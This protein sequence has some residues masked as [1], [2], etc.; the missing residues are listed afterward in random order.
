MRWVVFVLLSTLSSCQMEREAEVKSDGATVPETTFLN[1]KYKLSG[2]EIN[3]QGEKVGDEIVYERAVQ[4]EL[5]G[6]LPTF[7]RVKD[8]TPGKENEPIDEMYLHHSF[9]TSEGEVVFSGGSI[10]VRSRLY[11]VVQKDESLELGCTEPPAHPLTTIRLAGTRGEELSSAEWEELLAG[12][13]EE[14]NPKPTNRAEL[15]K[16]FESACGQLLM[17]SGKASLHKMHM[18]EIGGET[19]FSGIYH[20]FDAGGSHNYR[21]YGMGLSV[22]QFMMDNGFVCGLK[23]EN[24]TFGKDGRFGFNSLTDKVG[25]VLEDGHLQITTLDK[26]DE[27]GNIRQEVHRI[28]PNGEVTLNVEEPT[29]IKN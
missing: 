2:Y 14:P 21:I 24:L 6:G 10:Q 13:S 12:K 16:Y 29:S 17:K 11:T 7:L 9:T 23:G 26:P 1:F 18:L 4:F 19:H 15:N 5:H 8:L 25:V 22:F 3:A 27:D 20:K 28:A